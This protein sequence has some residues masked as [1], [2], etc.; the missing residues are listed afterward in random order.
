MEEN[1]PR[2]EQILRQHIFTVVSIFYRISDVHYVFV[3]YQICLRV[4]T[5]HLLGG[6]F[7]HDIF[8]FPL[9]SWKYSFCLHPLS[10][11]ISVSIYNAYIIF[12]YG[13]LMT[14]KASMYYF[15]EF[16]QFFQE[17]FPK[18]LFT[19]SKNHVYSFFIRAS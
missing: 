11:Q 9:F 16:K 4:I 10:L 17:V 6:D 18:Y 8:C 13:M 15:K 3:V 19:K 2:Q 14:R 12:S 1:I 5:Y 7:W